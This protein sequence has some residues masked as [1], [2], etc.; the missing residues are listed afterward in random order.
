MVET[1]L[2][3]STLRTLGQRHP[4]TLGSRNNL[5]M[6]L[7][8]RKRWKEAELLQRQVMSASLSELGLDH[9]VASTGMRLLAE[10][11]RTQEK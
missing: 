2:L 11:Y 5:A 8:K 6:I 10:I 3:E 7:G 9:S 1:Q 4:G